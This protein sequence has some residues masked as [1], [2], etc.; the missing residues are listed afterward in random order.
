MITFF[1]DRPDVLT[2]FT[3][4]IEA[5]KASYPVLLSN[6]NCTERGDAAEG[7]HYTVWVDPWPKPSYLFALVAGNLTALEDT[8]TTR[9]GRTVAL[10]VFTEAHNAHKTAFAMRSL[11]AAMKWD[12]ERYG[13]EYDL[14][15]FNIVSV[16]DF[17]MGAMEN[18]S[19]NVF[20]SR[21]VLASPQTATD[22]D[23]A[24]IEGVIGHEARVAR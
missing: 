8:F 9:S 20:N 6:G 5:D 3:V 13:L 12:E 14:D 17:N 22:D 24:A 16:D 10:R 7:R 4:R 18:K 21:L 1:P 11:K 2:R 15:L 23:Y 19:L